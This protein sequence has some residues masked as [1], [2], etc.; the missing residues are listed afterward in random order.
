MN[1]GT[2]IAISV[3][4]ALASV[5]PQPEDP[6]IAAKSYSLSGIPETAAAC[7]VRNTTGPAEVSHVHPLYGMERVAVVV[8][9]APLGDTVATI[10]IHAADPGSTAQVNTPYPVEDREALVKRLLAKC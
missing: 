4:S 1:P 5:A 10:F 9:Q 2:I 6:T 8:R 3:V 7:V